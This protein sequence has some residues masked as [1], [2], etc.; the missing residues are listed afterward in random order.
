MVV[1][2]CVQGNT[3]CQLEFDLMRYRDFTLTFDKLRLTGRIY[4]KQLVYKI[5]ML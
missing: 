4:W 2:V 1:I 5:G 3:E